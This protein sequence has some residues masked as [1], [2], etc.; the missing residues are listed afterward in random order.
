MKKWLSITLWVAV[1][2]LLHSTPSMALRTHVFFMGYPKAAIT[3]EIIE[4][5]F[6]NKT[7]KEKFMELQ[8]KAEL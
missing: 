3:S 5:E 2:V 6:H 1:F 4:D 8:A 7:D